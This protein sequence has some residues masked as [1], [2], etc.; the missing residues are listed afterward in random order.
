[1]VNMKVHVPMNNDI[2]NKENNINVICKVMAIEAEQKSK[3]KHPAQTKV[4]WNQ[5]K[6]LIPTFFGTP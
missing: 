6:L 3:D 2:H 1:M 5:T 4:K